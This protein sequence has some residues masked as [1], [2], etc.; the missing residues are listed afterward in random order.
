MRLS[1]VALFA[2]ACGEVHF[3][4]PNPPQLFRAQTKFTP[5]T[6]D[7]PI[8]W[9]V[10]FNLFF[11]D[12]PSC[13]WARDTALG[14]LRSG[15]AAASGQPMEL[16]AQDLAPGCQ[17][18]DLVQLDVTAVRAAFSSAQAAFP[19]G[20]VRPIIVYLDNIDSLLSPTTGAL[21][22][23]LKNAPSGLQSLI[24]TVGF[25]Q[26]A[27]QLGSDR[28][29]GWTY[30]GDPAMAGQIRGVVSSELPLRSTAARTTGPVPLLDSSQLELAHEIKV[31][32]LPK[33]LVP[34]EPPVLG[35][36]QVIDRARP[37]TLSFQLPEA[38]AL[39]RSL[40]TDVTYAVVTEGCSANCDRYFVRD[41]GD[42]PQRWDEMKRC[43]MV[44]R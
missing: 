33:D 2:I 3:I 9:I 44:T 40:Y 27:T 24:W 21:I 36:A 16:P 13:S 39:P 17:Q 14:A 11:E 7:E 10:I 15:F 28:R 38:V 8:V 4:D 35:A 30:T 41:P 34:D 5:A 26:V 12:A 1:L 20:R 23:S 37:P 42:P 18:R 25:D 19:S 32:V 6:V 43:A 22:V 29:I 31:C